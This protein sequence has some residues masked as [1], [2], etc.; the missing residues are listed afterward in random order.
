MKKTILVLASMV[1]CMALQAQFSYGPKVGLNLANLS[2]DDVDNNSML[3][4]FNA[5]VFGNYGINDM[6]SVQAEVNYEGKGAKFDTGDEDVNMVLG[7][8]TIPVLAKV[9]FGDNIKFYANAGPYIGLLMG[10]TWDG[11]SEYEYQQYVGLD[12]VTFQPIYQ[13][14][15]EKVKDSYKGTDFGA[16]I[17]AGAYFPL[18]DKMK[19][20]VDARYGLGLGTIAEKPDQ[21][22]TPDVK[23]GTIGISAGLVLGL[24]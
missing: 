6:F 22:D 19:I 12:P 3:I 11:E 5:G 4:S 16:V 15:T 7:Y 13:T 23:T 10:A 20:M 17:G 8:L 24:K 2:G 18:N 9:T 21:G 1:F 14:V